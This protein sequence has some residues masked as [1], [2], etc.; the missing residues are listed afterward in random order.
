MVLLLLG[1]SLISLLNDME[2]EGRSCFLF[3]V[4]YVDLSL[5]YS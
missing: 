5:W 1:L 3:V 4:V 2:W